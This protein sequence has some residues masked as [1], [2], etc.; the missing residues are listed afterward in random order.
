VAA[1]GVLWF[2]GFLVVVPFAPLQADGV[3]APWYGRLY[4]AG[5]TLAFAG[6]F[7]AAFRALGRCE[8][9][10]YFQRTRSRAEGDRRTEL[11]LAASMLRRCVGRSD[12]SA[13]HSGIGTRDLSICAPS[14]RRPPLPGTCALRTPS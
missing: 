1:L 7:L 10:N 9:R 11:R 5:V 8:T 14:S 3:P 2:L 12:R 13:Q 6:V 4:V